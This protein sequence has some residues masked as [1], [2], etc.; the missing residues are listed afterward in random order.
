MENSTLEGVCKANWLCHLGVALVTP[1]SSKF[2]PL[3]PCGLLPE[4]VFCAGVKQV[5]A[6]RIQGLF[7]ELNP[8]PLAPEARIM[9]LDQT[10]NCISLPEP[11]HRI[12]FRS[13]SCKASA[14]QKQ[15]GTKQV[16]RRKPWDQEWGGETISRPGQAAAP[17]SN[18][19]TMWALI[20]SPLH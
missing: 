6:L 9:P 14:A 5:C 15:Q 10:A 20:C 8:G 1:D 3:V 12:F 2:E 11:L 17:H 4:H 19:Q 7:W 13:A 18:H 16:R